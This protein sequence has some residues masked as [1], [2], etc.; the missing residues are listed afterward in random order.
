M[1]M[2]LGCLR[3]EKLDPC[4]LPVWIQVDAA[5]DSH[6]LSAAHFSRV[7]I[8]PAALHIVWATDIQHNVHVRTGVYP[9]HRL[10]IDWQPV[11]GL[12][13][14]SICASESGVFALTGQGKVFRRGGITKDNF[15]GAFWE[16]LVVGESAL[17]GLAVTVCDRVYGVTNSTGKLVELCKRKIDLSRGQSE[18]KG[19]EHARQ[20]S[21]ESCEDWTMVK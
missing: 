1:W 2:R 18:I 7:A 13:A 8:S 11:A 9:D 6:S 15:V 14:V 5:A 17:S 12:K 21:T 19:V 20:I 10:G 16:A 3:P 4:A